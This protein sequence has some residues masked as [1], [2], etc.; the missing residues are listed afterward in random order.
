M[1]TNKNR[2]LFEGALDTTSA[3]QE[4]T[5]PD[6]QQGDR[7]RQRYLEGRRTTLARIAAGELVNK[8]LHLVDP[9]R[10]RI[11]EHHNRRY[12]LLN[13]MRCKD[14]VDSIKAQGGQE[15][16]AVVRCISGDPSYDY[17]VICGARRHWAVTWLRAHHYDHRF[18]IE[19]R[20]LNDEEAFRL[21]DIE[22][23]DRED[24][25]DYERATDYAPDQHDLLSVPILGLRLI[26]SVKN[27]V[28]PFYQRRK[29]FPRGRAGR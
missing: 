17:E 15:F 7:G 16:P 20:D 2:A 24:I 5:A 21:S 9:A 19:I 10:C 22:N 8:T 1:T 14:L 11:W 6:E 3:G 4:S 26:G 28:A 12:E 27:S 29:G 25:S 18:L 13:E 23:R